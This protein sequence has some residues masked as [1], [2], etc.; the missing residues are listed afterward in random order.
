MQCTATV[1]GQAEH[2]GGVDGSGT[3]ITGGDGAGSEGK[4]FVDSKLSDKNEESHVIISKL[5]HAWYGRLA[6]HA[7]SA[8]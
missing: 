2:V 6:G 4:S 1:L 7:T 8:R 3:S 5:F